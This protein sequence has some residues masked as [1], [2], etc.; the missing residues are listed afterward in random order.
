M[1]SP[2]NFELAVSA[3]DALTKAVY[4]RTFNWLVEK[5]NKSLA[6][7]VREQQLSPQKFSH[8]VVGFA[9]VLTRLCGLY[10]QE[11]IYHSSK[12]ASVIGLLDIYGF[13]VLQHNR[14]N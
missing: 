9:P 3:R 10:M 13:E 6:L 1:I 4:G 14:C 11:Q 2:L 7:Q 5:I 8:H 12:D